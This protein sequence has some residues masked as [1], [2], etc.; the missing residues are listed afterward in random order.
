MRWDAEEGLT[1]DNECRDGEDGVGGQVVEAQPVVEYQSADE[2]V[3][4]E[5]QS[6]NEVGEKHHPFLGLR[7][8]DDLPLGRSR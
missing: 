7:G 4:G 2:R 3:E 1:H 5:S 8:R 6:V